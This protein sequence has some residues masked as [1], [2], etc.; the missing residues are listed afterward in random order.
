MN[1]L[2]GSGG[3]LVAASVGGRLFDACEPWTP[4]AMVGAAQALLFL[5]ALLI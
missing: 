4:R 1:G 3:I 2:F 5:A